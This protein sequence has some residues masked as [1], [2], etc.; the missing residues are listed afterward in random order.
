MQNGYFRLVS[1]PD[2]YGIAIYP[3]QDGGEEIRLGDL[4]GYL[5]GLGI[6]YDRKRIEMQL[7]DELECVCHLASGDCPP[8]PETYDLIVDEEGM[9]AIVRFIPPSSTGN[10]ITLNDF[11]K[12]IRLKGITFGLQTDL[13]QRHFSTAGIYGTDIIIAK[14]QEPTQGTDAQIAYCLGEPFRRFS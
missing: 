2:G 9:T 10:R 14:G 13:L 4:L 11:M 1:E 6:G 5:D 12:D 8:Y 7:M 3:P